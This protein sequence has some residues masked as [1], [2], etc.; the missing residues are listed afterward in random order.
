MNAIIYYLALP[1]LYL[2]SYLPFKLLY[3]LSDGFYVL[4]YTVF[5]YRKKIV[6]ENLKQSFPDKSS[7][8][9]EHIRRGFYHY[10]CDLALETIKTLSISPAVLKKHFSHDDISVL[11]N[12]F[13]ENQSVIIIMG[14]LG[15]WELGGAYFSQILVHQVYAI[16]H[17]MANR[18]FDRFFCRMRTRSGAR[19]YP[20]KDA[21]KGM[22]RNR[23]EVTATVFIADQT[24]APE[25]AHW[26][27]FMNQDT[28]VLK[29]TEIIARKL[30]YPVIYVSAI[31]EKRGQ[32]KIHFE[33][34]V[35]HPQ[36][37]TK[38]ELTEVHTK[39]LQQDIIDYPETW[40]WS[41]RRWKHKKP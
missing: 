39:R 12:Y 15:S 22:I 30:D 41:H 4:V 35:E 7:A 21:F 3:L 26:M 10:L 23:N 8:E 25:N 40:L 17:P 28:P 37:L 24:P 14:H 31:R 2:I 9:L 33:L 20:M 32:Y 13:N 18:H 5:A 11:E 34:L 16:Y 38:N 1:F 36:R 29:G 19:L 27:T 6:T